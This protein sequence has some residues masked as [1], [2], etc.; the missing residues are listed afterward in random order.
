LSF[1]FHNVRISFPI[2]KKWEKSNVYFR[3]SFDWNKKIF[4]N[5][6]V[7]IHKVHIYIF[8]YTANCITL[9]TLRKSILQNAHAITGFAVLQIK[10]VSCY[11]TFYMWFSLKNFIWWIKKF[12]GVFWCSLN[13]AENFRMM[14][15]KI[16]ACSSLFLSLETNLILCLYP[17]SE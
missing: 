5:R 8:I 17:E 10:N 15:I 12:L 4:L 16:N 9:H 6:G 1:Y 13:W 11:V 3:F 2:S 7:F 14:D